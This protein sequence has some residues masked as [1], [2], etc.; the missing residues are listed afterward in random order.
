MSAVI[1]LPNPFSR[2]S[3]RPVE[4]ESCFSTLAEL[5]AYALTP[6][7]YTGQIVSVSGTVTPYIIN[8][9]FTV[10]PL[11]LQSFTDGKFLPLS[12]GF[13]TGN[14]VS[15]AIISANEIDVDNIQLEGNTIS[16]VNTNGDLTLS[17]NGTG[18]VN[19]SRVD[20]D[21]GTIDNVTIGGANAAISI[22]AAL[23]DVD[24]I[25]INNNDITSTN[26]NGDISLTPN[27]TGEVN[28]TRVD[29]DAGTIDNVTVG[30]TTAAI[31]ISSALLNVDN[32][33]VDGNDITSTNTNGDI[34]LTP[35]GTG[36]VNIS[37]VDIDAGTIDNVTI[38]GTTAAISISSALLNVD[39]IRVD[40]NDITSTNT[41]GDISL[42]P[43]GTGEVNI[44]RVDIDAG[45]ID[46]VTI[47]GTTAAISISSALLDVDNIRV[48]GNS[49]TSTNTNGNIALTPNGTGEVDISRVDIDAGTIDNVTIGGTTAAISVSSALLNVDN[50]R[51]DGNDITSTNTNGDISLTPNGTGEVNISRVDIDA[52]TLDNVTIGGTTAAIS[53]SSALLNVDNIRVDGNTISSTNSNGNI[54]LEPNGTGDVFVDADTLRVGDSG[55]AATFTTNGSGNLTINTNG[56]TNA[57]SIVLNAG[58]NGNIDI[59]PNGSGQVNLPRVNIDAGTIDGTTIGLTTPA[60]AAF[61]GI[62]VGGNVNISGNLFVAGSS[63]QINTVDLVVKD[64]IIFLAEGN[65][66]DTVDIGFTAAYNHDLTPKRHTGFIRNNADGKW[67][68]FSNLSVE[69]LSATNIPLDNNSIVID[70]LRANIE[71]TITGNV[72]GVAAQAVRLVTGRTIS[73]TGDVNY[74]SGS[75]DGTGN[76][77]GTATISSNVVT[78]AKIQKAG[79]NTIIGNP[80]GSIADVQE[81]TCTA[82]GR[83]L[84]DDATAADQRNTLGVGS[85]QSVTFADVTVTNTN[86]KSVLSRVYNGTVTGGNTFTLNTFPSGGYFSAKYTVQ[87]KDTSSNERCALEIIAT[88]NNGTWE[89][90]VYGIVD[91]G[92]VFVNVDVGLTATVNLEFTLNGVS[93]YTIIA[94]TQAITD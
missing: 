94:Y 88:N 89:G 41:N 30:G 61:T 12:G 92:T 26:T 73:T 3:R 25:R 79:A 9:D 63:T 91:P 56:G 69:V 29:I 31:S 62:T 55:Q 18:E 57:G 53:I 14:I 42:T 35:N 83:A 60:S 38:G 54:V 71:G 52:G 20:I 75:F 10:Q 93:N 37:R 43:N 66:G 59:T 44:S 27:G 34:S 67:T 82:A 81:I 2:T 5:T 28:I 21:A 84:I 65:Q 22:S 24:N 46:N 13:V 70:T 15:T 19:I 40:G 58:T 36:E 33:R 72:S 23:L 78:Y 4:R 85:A 7:A 48:D 11:A 76:V 80:T 68:L 77:T 74:T 49:I 17:P 64:P 86:S 32:I 87:I 1:T 90:T 39:N 8:T 45:T 47:G 6:I 16:I 51:I 50:I